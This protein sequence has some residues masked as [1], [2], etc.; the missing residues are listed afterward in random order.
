MDPI[1]VTI[2]P[3]PDKTRVLMSRGHQDL[4]KAV[5][6]APSEA[7]PIAAK[8]L[9]EGLSLWHQQQLSVVLLAD[10]SDRS[11]AGLYLCDV[12]GFPE[13]T[14]HYEVAVVCRERRPT[15]RR[16][17]GVDDFRD[18]RQLSVRGQR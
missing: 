14:L 15:R 4:M 3:E 1:I 18:L 7:H 9:L 12:L 2:A 6:P 8:T 16:I 11:S 10:E 17:A 5:L 13:R